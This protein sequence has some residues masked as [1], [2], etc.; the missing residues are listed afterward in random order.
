MINGNTVL[1]TGGAGSVGRSLIP[2]LLDRD[3][4][5]LRIFDS[6][7]SGLASLKSDISDERCRFFAGNVRD[8]NRLSRAM[9]GVDVVI[10]TLR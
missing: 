3:P 10:H 4:Q 9:S 1:L 8:S 5:T 7:E 6:S 2:R